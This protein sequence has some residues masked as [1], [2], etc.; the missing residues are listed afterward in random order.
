M[1]SNN[2]V[3]PTNVVTLNGTAEANSTVTVFDGTTQLGT[4]TA[5]AS[6]AWSYTTAALAS[7]A[8]SFTA[9]DTD[10]A[11]NTGAASSSVNMT[12]NVPA[13]TIA[14]FSTD[15]GTVGDDITNDNTLT[16]TGTAPTSSTVNVYDGA[17]LLGTATA[18]SSGAWS[19]T[20]ATL[21]NGTHSFTATDTVSG[22]TSAASSALSVTVD[23][24]AP[25]APVI[26]NNSVASTNVVT[27]NGTAE[28]N[29]TVTVFDGTTQLGTAT[30]NASGAW[31]YATAAL[32]AGSHSFT[33]K[34]TD[35]AGNTSA[36]SS[37]LNLT[38]T[39]PVT[40]VNLVVNGSFETGDFTGWT[41]GGNYT[42][43]ALG[44]E[45]YIDQPR[46]ERSVCRWLRP[47]RHGWDA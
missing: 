22:T 31:S 14:S 21:A 40:P 29:S 8:H 36:A 20:T 2:S 4:A 9:K 10:A 27:L 32:P 24:V 7:G 15:S 43:T 44:P 16:L 30:A 5:N 19:F 25:A 28:A 34:D 6:G 38:L 46:A 37:A 41:L 47:H 1:I 18:N 35:A 11:G 17:T 45:I 13:P 23:T 33:A 39:A 3:S 12:L 26:S 42:S